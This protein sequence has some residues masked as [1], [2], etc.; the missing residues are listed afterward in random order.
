[1]T[2][3]SYFLRVHSYPTTSV[4]VSRK[5]RTPLLK[6]LLRERLFVDVNSLGITEGIEQYSRFF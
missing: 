2:G 1:M 4:P 6:Q 5:K 3:E